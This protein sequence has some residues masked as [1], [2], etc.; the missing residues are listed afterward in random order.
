MTHFRNICIGS[1]YLYAFAF[2]IMDCNV[3]VFIQSF[4][5]PWG[6]LQRVLWLFQRPYTHINT[7]LLPRLKP[8]PNCVVSSCSTLVSC[9][10]AEAM[11][12]SLFCQPGRNF[13]I[14]DFTGITSASVAKAH[15]SNCSSNTDF[16]LFWSSGRTE[17]CYCTVA[18]RIVRLFHIHSL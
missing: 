1:F 13:S 6:V 12:I 7:Q 3:F 2:Y 10:S 15:R 11:E 4:L 17:P 18:K 8:Q 16:E 9:R 5:R 14:A